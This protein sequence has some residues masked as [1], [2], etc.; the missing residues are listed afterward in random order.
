MDLTKEIKI[1]INKGI[2]NNIYPSCSVGINYNK[3]NK[4]KK[5]IIKSDNLYKKEKHMSSRF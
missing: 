5:L 2:H 3:K 1:I 4:S